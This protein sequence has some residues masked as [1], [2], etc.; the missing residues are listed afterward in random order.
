[1]VCGLGLAVG[2][3]SAADV[4]LYQVTGPVVEIT[5]TYVVVQKGDDKW[6]VVCDPATLGKA[7]VG[8]NVTVQYQV[9]AK[10]VELKGDKKA[11]KKLDKK[12]EK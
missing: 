5:P 6:Q 2:S 1:M 9:V 7:K 8:D 11:G 12:A 4:K 3:A 10:K